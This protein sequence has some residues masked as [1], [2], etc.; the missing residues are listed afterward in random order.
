MCMIEV[1]CNYQLAEQEDAF[2]CHVSWTI[3]PFNLFP[4]ISAFP[5]CADYVMGTQQ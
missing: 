2:Y 1:Y 4:V 5:G 3:A